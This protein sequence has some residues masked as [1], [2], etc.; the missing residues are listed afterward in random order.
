M[1]CFIINKMKEEK[2]CNRFYKLKSIRKK[3]K[4]MIMNIMD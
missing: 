2:E 4:I 3:C 1:C